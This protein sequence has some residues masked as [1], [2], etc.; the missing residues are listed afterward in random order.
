MPRRKQGRTSVSAIA[1]GVTQLSLVSFVA[2]LNSNL[3]SAVAQGAGD[4][5]L[6]DSYQGNDAHFSTK[7]GI[8]PRVGPR[9]PEI[10]YEIC[11]L[12]HNNPLYYYWNG[13]G[14]GSGIKHPVPFSNCAILTRT[15]NDY[16]D[17]NTDVLFT[18]QNTSWPT[19]AYVPKDKRG[20]FNYFYSAIVA[21]FLDNDTPS[22]VEANIL[23][24]NADGG[25]L[26]YI[27]TWSPNVAKVAIGLTYDAVS[28]DGRKNITDQ[29]AKDKISAEFI[30]G[31]VLPSG[32][33]DRGR[34]GGWI[35]EAQYLV[36]PSAEGKWTSANFFM[37]P[38]KGPL[39]RTN[40]LI[41]FDSK[42]EIITVVPFTGS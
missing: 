1:K 32:T 19:R 25:R 5:V 41:L 40:A 17:K 28:N 26:Q 16:E 39:L 11:N 37:Q 36:M 30:D 8:I 3:C 7:S 14:F 24:S 18:I 34:Y 22:V 15:V 4:S 12:D 10:K 23:V 29:L 13:A 38:D 27:I 2:F 21:P 6:L 9:S 42:N 35:S 20:Y 31:K 33:E